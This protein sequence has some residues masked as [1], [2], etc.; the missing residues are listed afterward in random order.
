MTLVTTST[1]IFIGRQ[2]VI[3]VDETDGVYENAAALAGTYG[4]LEMVDITN[5]D[6]GDDGVIWSDEVGTGDYIEYT[7]D[8]VTYSSPQDAIILYNA[9]I[10]ERD[11]TVHNVEVSVIQAPNGDTFINDIGNTGATDNLNIKTIELVNPTATDS[12]GRNTFASTQNTAVCFGEDTLITTPQGLRPIQTL[13]AGDLVT[14]LGG[15]HMPIE[16]VGVS[17]I[18]AGARHAPIVLETG[19]IAANLPTRRLFLSP[20]HRVLVTSAIVRRMFHCHSIFVA[21]KFL[22]PIPG[23][24]QPE[25]AGRVA[26]WHILCRPHTVI[27]ANGVA[28][29]TLFPG[30][31]ALRNLPAKALA[32]IAA[33]TKEDGTQ[34][35]QPCFKVP[36]PPLQR[37]LVARHIKNSKSLTAGLAARHPAPARPASLALNAGIGPLTRQNTLE[38]ARLI[39]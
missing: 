15:A 4:D 12:A 32:T 22:S 9:I 29:E 35:A 31:V 36:P 7:I 19:A 8:G 2:T 10:T 21:A 37:E 28:V 38:P 34:F 26:Y 6:V 25:A 5:Y 11:G 13:R 3:D 24:S 17:H 18:A 23:V 27:F 20:Q 30:P 33:I 16:W 39:Q 1:M 14:T